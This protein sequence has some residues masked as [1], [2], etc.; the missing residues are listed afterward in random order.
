MSIL[1]EDDI[2]KKKTLPFILGWQIIDK[3]NSLFFSFDVSTADIE[4]FQLTPT[5]KLQL[6]G[7]GLNKHDNCYSGHSAAL[8]IVH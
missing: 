1:E 2:V 6:L 7:F 4:Y 5:L 3:V 8:F